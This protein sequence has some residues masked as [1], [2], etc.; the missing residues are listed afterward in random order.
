MMYQDRTRV[1]DHMAFNRLQHS[2][3]D[4]AGVNVRREIIGGGLLLIAGLT[5]AVLLCVAFIPGAN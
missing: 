5:I 3:W 4:K 2:K 1:A